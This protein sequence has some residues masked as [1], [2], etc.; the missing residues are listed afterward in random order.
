MKERYF[1]GFVKKFLTS[2]LRCK[3]TKSIKSV[4]EIPET[5]AEEAMEAK[6]FDMFTKLAAIPKRNE[7][8]PREHPER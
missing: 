3:L 7:R 6:V 2:D 8:G 5:K 1:I 4:L